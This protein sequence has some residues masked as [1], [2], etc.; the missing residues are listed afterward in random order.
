MESQDELKIGIG[1]KEPQ[2]LEPAEVEVQGVKVDVKTNSD[3]KEVGRLAVLLCKHPNKDDLIQIS[4]VKIIRNDKVKL[5]S[6]WVNLDE[7]KMISKNSALAM[8][9]KF[10]EVPTLGELS[11]KKLQTVT[12]SDSNNFL[13]IKAY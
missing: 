11:G 8:F 5:S 10:A 3:G 13:C 4:Q 9:L 6:L 1:T 7:D 12:Q 2:V